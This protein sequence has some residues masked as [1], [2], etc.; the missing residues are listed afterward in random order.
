MY[1]SAASDMQKYSDH[2]YFMDAN[3]QTDQPFVY[4][5]NGSNYSLQ[6]DAGNSRNSYHQFLHELNTM[7][8]RMPSILVLTHW[9]WDHTFGVFAAECPVI[10][11]ELTNEILDKVSRWE[12]TEEA[13]KARLE[14]GEDI[15][16]TYEC[17]HREYKNL[18]DIHV[19]KADITFND[20]MTVDLG[21]VTCYLEHRDSP[22]TRDAVFI[23]IP[24]DRIL[25]GGDAH[26]EDYYDNNSQ[27]DKDRLQSFIA[28]LNSV[29]FDNYLKGHDEPAISKT[30]LL[31]YLNEK[32]A[33]LL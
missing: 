2:I 23:Y 10:S 12:W 20:K 33:E 26:Y 24:E 19:G 15:P 14:S 9:H 27:Y 11:S 21:G 16:F 22:H 6:I 1:G 32:L 31:A 29:D 18:S 7:Q 13:M 5:V 4:Y 30:D 8:L 25:I 17:I 3:D 28:Y